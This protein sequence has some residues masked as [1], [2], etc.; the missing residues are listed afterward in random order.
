[1]AVGDPTS[2]NVRTSVVKDAQLCLLVYSVDLMVYGTMQ[3]SL[4]AVKVKQS[5]PNC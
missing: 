4:V 5:S 3:I 1:M 2:P